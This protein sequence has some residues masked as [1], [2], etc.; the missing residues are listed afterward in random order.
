LLPSAFVSV[1][2][3]RGLIIP[4]GRWVI[5]EAVRQ[6]RAW[7]DAG[8]SVR[9]AINISAIQFKQKDLVEDIAQKLA[10]YALPGEWIELE[11]TESL[12]LEDVSAMTRTLRRLKDLGVTLSVDDFGT[13]YSA[14]AYLKRYPIDKIKIDRSFISDLPH[15]EDDAAITVAII[16][17]AKALSLQ[18]KPTRRQR[19]CARTSAMS[20]R[21]RS[22]RRRCQP[23]RRWCGCRS[24]GEPRVNLRLHEVHV[25]DGQATSPTR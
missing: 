4:I 3:H 25:G 6:A 20:F 18:V 10:E 13:G 14:L 12:F 1:A 19:F 17:L 7:R 24:A 2:E 22:S 8:T 5:G 9:V 16:N 21:A 11:L 23:K 15:G